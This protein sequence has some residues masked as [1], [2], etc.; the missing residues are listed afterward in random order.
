MGYELAIPS[1]NF[2][3]AAAAKDPI[4]VLTSVQRGQSSVALAANTP[5]EN[6]EVPQQNAFLGGGDLGNKA[7]ALIKR[8][9]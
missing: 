2:G 8:D 3:T 1:S 4:S 7:K 5:K 9:Y 6:F